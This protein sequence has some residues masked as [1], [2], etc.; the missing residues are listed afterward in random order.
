MVRLISAR[1]FSVVTA[2]TLEKARACVKEGNV[3]FLIADL[4]LPDGN[5][6]DLMRE[7]RTKGIKGTAISGFGMDDD[8]ERSHAAG[9]SFHLTKPIAIADLDH[10]LSMAKLSLTLPPSSKK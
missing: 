9:F 10:V 8:M 5:A 3:G 7:L 4:G 2:G 1:G 6:C